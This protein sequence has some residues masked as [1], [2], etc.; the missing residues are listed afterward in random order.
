MPEHQ[1]FLPTAL[2]LGRAW[3]QTHSAG[4]WSPHLSQVGDIH[5]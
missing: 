1:K 2:T 3:E 4:G 5:I